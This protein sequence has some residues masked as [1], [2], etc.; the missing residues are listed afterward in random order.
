VIIAL[1]LGGTR[2]KAGLVE[3]GRVI[4]RAGLD[5]NSSGGL[6]ARLDEL[7]RLIDGLLDGRHA[8]GLGFALPG[9]V[10]R[11]AGRL[12]AINAKWADAVDI[13]LP[14]WAAQHWGVTAW[15]ENDA[16]AALAGEWRCG[17]GRGEDGV[18][19]LTLGTGL[20]TAAVVEGRLLRGSHGQ[21]CIAG[22]VTVQIDGRLC[23]CGNRGCAEA[24]A[25]TAVLPTI[26]KALPGYANSRLASVEVL[27]YRAVF[28]LA[29]QD[30]LARFLRDRALSVWGALVVNLIHTHD[31]T[32]VLVGGGIAR[33]GAQ[34]F[35]PLRAT[36][37]ERAW[38]PWG[39]VDIRPTA[40]GDDAALLGLAVIHEGY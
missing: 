39:R 29:E 8:R 19:L 7:R 4:A 27:D 33:A 23:S 22:H 9:L 20:G 5:S 38:T 30:P 21:A 26:A 35:E 12:R 10:D 2:I 34:L 13:D 16:V 31:P 36:V 11:A 24:E 28:A 25:S 17:A 18:V 40:L 32:V 37:K 3:D 6:A 14:A 1:D 15:F